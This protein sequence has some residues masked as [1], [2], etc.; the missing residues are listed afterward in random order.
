MEC[1]SRK[2]RNQLQPAGRPSV[3]CLSTDVVLDRAVR[4][5]DADGDKLAPRR[6]KA[7]QNR[8]IRDGT[9]A[10]RGVFEISRIHESQ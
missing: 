7:G 8:L 6:K 10:Q 1:R 3:R 5:L 2:R 9:T 4:T